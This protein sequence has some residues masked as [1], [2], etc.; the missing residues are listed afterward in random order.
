MPHEHDD[1]VLMIEYTS[2]PHAQARAHE[3]HNECLNAALP[4][5]ALLEDEG[6]R[7]LTLSLGGLRS[8]VAIGD[9]QRGTNFHCAALR[10]TISLKHELTDVMR[11][12]SI[13]LIYALVTADIDLQL[14]MRRRWCGLLCKLLRRAKHLHLNLPWRPMFDKL[15]RHSSSKLRQAEYTSRAMA[16]S[17]VSALAR[18]A[19]QARRHWPV[20]SSAEILDAVEPMLCAK[21]P[22][23]YTGAALLSLLLPTHASEGAVW[24]ARAL[25][26][27]RGSAVEGCIEWELL[28]LLLFKRLAKDAFVGRAAPVVPWGALL[29]LL[30]T[31]TLLLLH[32]PGGGSG[33]LAPK[34]GF[35]HLGRLGTAAHALPAADGRAASGGAAARPRPRA[36]TAG[37]RCAAT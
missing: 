28:F 34:G 6:V 31:R 26:L 14:S 27:W 12:E 18:C 33:A 20:G 19:A 37:R 8:A 36:A 10:R 30:M 15:V 17:H 2:T 21:D 9:L 13:R 24:Q 35:V 32:L 25:A 7:T 1:D 16:H 29:P 5:S 4:Y 22:Q 3:L 23:L 11:A